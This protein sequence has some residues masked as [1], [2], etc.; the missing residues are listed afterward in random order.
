MAKKINISDTFPK[1]AFWDMDTNKLSTQR[2]RAIII[3]RVLMTTNEDTFSKDIELVE[4]V[5]S[6]NEIYTTLK[7]T[8][9]RIS[10]NVCR[11]VSKRYNKPTFLRYDFS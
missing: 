5:Y 6:A 3:P 10:N 11:L 2:D 8:K 4:S 7:D 9:E 1:Q